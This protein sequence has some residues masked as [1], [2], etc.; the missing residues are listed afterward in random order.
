[1]L[2]SRKPETTVAALPVSQPAQ[3]ART[4]G[5]LATVMAVVA[6]AVP[7]AAASAQPLL[8]TLALFGALHLGLGKGASLKTSAACAVPAAAVAHW[9]IP[10]YPAFGFLILGG[11]AGWAAGSGITDLATRAAVM[12]GV[13]IG[14]VTG[15]LLGGVLASSSYL[16]GLIPAPVVTG[17][18]GALQGLLVGL[19]T[20]PRHLPIER[21]PVEVQ[22][23]QSR[24]LP[25]AETRDYLERSMRLYRQIRKA[26]AEGSVPAREA[27]T[28]HFKDDLGNLM[29]AM[30]RLAQRSREIDAFLEH[31]SADQTR[32]RLAANQTKLTELADPYA[33]RQYEQ[34]AASLER[35]LL[36]LGEMQ[37]GKERVVSSLSYYFTTLEDMHLSLMRLKA[38]DAQSASLELNSLAERIRALNDEIDA[39]ARSVEELD[40]GASAEPARLPQ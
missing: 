23:E 21:D 27:E 17:V 31:A 11:F 6:L 35:R 5:V 20:L 30:F 28:S 1:M 15:S 33:R 8:L 16:A 24:L 37:A 9:V 36:Q 34:I 32:A 38:T 10:A 4:L 29:T 26:I 40:F 25:G 22:F 14:T 3:L 13:G 2:V 18:A 39:T 12:F 7:L 19:G